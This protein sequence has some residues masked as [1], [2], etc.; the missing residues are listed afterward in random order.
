MQAST[1]IH[2]RA[3]GN[4]WLNEPLPVSLPAHGRLAAFPAKERSLAHTRRAP[5]EH[6]ETHV[7]LLRGRA[8]PRPRARYKNTPWSDRERLTAPAL[9]FPAPRPCPFTREGSASFGRT[10]TSS[11]DLSP[12]PR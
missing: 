9:P 10:N 11:R 2:A 4:R 6:G 8:G 1:S 12:S 7:R 5:A 3:I